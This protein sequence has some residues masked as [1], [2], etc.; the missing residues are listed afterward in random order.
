V[1]LTI[2]EA[3]ERKDAFGSLFKMPETWRNWFVFLKYLFAL[4]IKEQSER[5]LIKSSCGF[6]K[7]VRAAR[8]FRECYLICGRRSGKSF[9]SALIACYLS[10]FFDWSKYLSIGERAYV[11]IIATDRLQSRIIFNYVK[12]FLNST[13]K[14]RRYIEAER[15]DEISLKNKIT[16]AI[17]TASFRSVRGWT[18][19]AA[20]LEE[21]AFYRNEFSANPDKEILSAL[22]PSLA[23]IPESLLLGISTPYYRSG[24]L[25]DQFRKHFGKAGDPLI[26]K[27]PTAVMNPTIDK[28][29]IASQ[30]AEDPAAGAAEWLAEFRSDLERF[31]P[32]EAVAAAV[33]PSRL[34]LSFIREFRY[35]AFID[36]AGGSGA[37]AFTLAISHKEKSGAVIL[38]LIRERRPPF[39]PAEVVKE[40]SDTLKSYGLKSAV[41]DRYGG[42]WVKESFREFGVTIK[43]S[44]LSKSEIY[45]EFLPMILSGQVELLDDRKLCG[46]LQNLERRTRSGGRDLVDHPAGLH[47]DL[48]N[49]VAGSCVLN[50]PKHAGA[51]FLIGGVDMY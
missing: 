7:F 14:L 1:K 37:D 41:G 42:E 31:L 51:I 29:F 27:A 12:G 20:I 15:M 46:Q 36:A 44:E 32:S 16:I 30:L 26:W 6:E 33:I 21:V 11:L 39:S 50:S 22:R 38:D 35:K 9:V 5:E 19:V 45:L 23:T 24:V 47:D 43:N 18:T 4:P 49:S 10:I 40:F 17:K 48:A 13:P 34:E 2:L 8:P 28:E 25:F 3:I